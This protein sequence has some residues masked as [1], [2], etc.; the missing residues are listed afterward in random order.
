MPLIPRLP[1]IPLMSI[2]DV[3]GVRT[4]QSVDV[5]DEPEVVVDCAVYVDGQRLPGPYSHVAAADTVADLIA[6]GVDAFLWLGLLEPAEV[7]MQSVAVV[8]GL[9]PLIVHG[10]V[11]KHPRPRREMY[12]NAMTMTVKTV[13]YI[14]HATLAGAKEIV[15]TGEIMMI[16]AGDFLV[17][18]RH[19]AHGRLMG[20]RKRLEAD[21]ARMALGPAS[22]ME[23][24]VES[25]V[26]KYQD[27]VDAFESD[28]DAVQ[29]HVFVAETVEIERT[30]LLK[31]ELIELRRGVCALTPILTALG[32]DEDGRLPAKVRGH[33]RSTAEKNAAIAERLTGYDE[34]L[35]SLLD[36]GLGKIGN[37]QNSDMRKISAAAAVAVVPTLIAGIYGMNFDNMPELHWVWGYPAALGLMVVVCGLLLV[38]FR[39]HDWI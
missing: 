38:I 37:Q 30:Y 11:H 10:A 18:V 35:E 9:D 23:A 34:L 33:V 26:G 22:V 1:R 29:E 31:R 4:E 5:D 7:D 25:V 3:V 13:D 2:T 19:G 17:T 14:D 6:Q 8:H 28:V 16:V 39:R 27:V 12:D 36:A 20:L 21:V 32:A 15:H 24:I